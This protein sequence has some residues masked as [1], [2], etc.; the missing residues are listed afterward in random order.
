MTEKYL[1]VGAT[2]SIG[3]NLAQQMND[4]GHDIHL[5]GRDETLTKSLSEKLNSSYTISN[6]LN[7]GFVDA[8]KSDINDIKGIAYC[9]GSIDLKPI[10]MVIENDFNKCMKLNLYSAVHL[11]KGFQEQNIINSYLIKLIISRTQ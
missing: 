7:D 9:V 2:G 4:S 3:S 5:V 8:I 6:V 10:R 1:I 11:I